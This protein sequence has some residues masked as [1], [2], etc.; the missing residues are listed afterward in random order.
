MLKA[1]NRDQT[2]RGKEGFEEEQRRV[3]E[4]YRGQ[5]RAC[6]SLRPEGEK[7]RKVQKANLIQLKAYSLQKG[8]GFKKNPKILREQRE[9]E[10]WEKD[11]NSSTRL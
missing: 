11:V 1:K 4:R 9:R 5:E 2:Y 8:G 6:E 10:I 7:L 3:R